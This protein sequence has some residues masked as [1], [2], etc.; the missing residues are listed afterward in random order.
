MN[1]AFNREACHLAGQ[2]LG[3]LGLIDSEASCRLHLLPAA[4]SNRLLKSLK[5]A[6]L[7]YQFSR[8]FL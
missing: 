4:R 5:Q 6:A 3:H 7:Q 1:Q 8:S 2:Q